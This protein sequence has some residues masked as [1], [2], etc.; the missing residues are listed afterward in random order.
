MTGYGRL[1]SCALTCMFADGDLFGGSGWYIIKGIEGLLIRKAHPT[2]VM[3]LK[4]LG[5][6]GKV[7]L[8]NIIVI[9]AKAA[10]SRK[11]WISLSGSPWEELPM[12]RRS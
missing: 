11:D 9:S 10:T 1:V 8:R 3:V 4:A 2:C 12:P 6:P 7:P 5:T